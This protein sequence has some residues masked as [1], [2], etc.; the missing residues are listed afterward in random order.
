MTRN[1]LIKRQVRGFVLTWSM[2]TLIITGMTFFGIYLTYT[3]RSAQAAPADVRAN[4]A[5]PTITQVGAAIAQV[6]LPPT[7][8]PTRTPLPS[9]TSVPATA[10]SI[11]ATATLAPTQDSAGVAVAQVSLP[12][13]TPVVENQPT[14]IPGPTAEPTIPPLQLRNFE[15]GIQ[16]QPDNNANKKDQNNW[17]EMV[18]RDLA[19]DWMKIQV[20]WEYIELEKGVYDWTILDNAVR[21]ARRSKVKI[22]ASV[23]TSPDW[24]YPHDPAVTT[25]GPPTD[26]QDYVNFLAALLNQY[27]GDIQAIEVWNEQNLD[28]E[29]MTAR[30]LR[31]DDYVELLRRSYDGIKAVDPNVMVISGALSTTGGG[32]NADTGVPFAIDDFSYFDGMIAAGMLNYA[33]C[34]GAHH[35]GY[36]LAPDIRWDAVPDDPTATFRGPF[37]NAHHSWSFRSTLEYYAEKVAAAGGTQQLCVTE[38]GWA[39]GEDLEGVPAGWDYA[40]DNTLA[41]QAE[42]LPAAATLMEQSGFV[43]LAIIWNLNY[44]PSAGWSVTNDNV[45]YSLIGPEYTRRPGFF[46]IQEWNRRYK[47]LIQ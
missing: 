10:T 33:D 38:F 27:P 37:D 40:V 14:E 3:P 32:T 13:A 20:R 7:L 5:F 1:P 34:I 21:A 6:T 17:S 46:T 9:A 4:A 22:L 25:H 42:W 36:N 18:K 28:R 43:R 8:D 44:G 15:L 35:N 45:P 11:P 30:G 47:G 16:V 24:A 29:W 41:E 19:M 39:S 31:A 2:L 26:T 12:T 23:V